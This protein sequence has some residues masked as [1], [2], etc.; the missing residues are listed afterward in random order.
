MKRSVKLD[1]TTLQKMMVV[2]PG[3]G[4]LSPEIFFFFGGGAVV[5][6]CCFFIGEKDF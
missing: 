6:V 3:I 1:K 4:D 2:L 5:C